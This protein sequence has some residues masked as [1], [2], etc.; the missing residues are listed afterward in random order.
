MIALIDNSDYFIYLVKG[1][2]LI[3]PYNPPGFLE[4]QVKDAHTRGLTGDTL[5]FRKGEPSSPDGISLTRNTNL[6]EVVVSQRVLERV[7]HDN[8]E[9]GTRYDG[10]NKLTIKYIN[11][12]LESEFMRIYS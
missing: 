2:A 7:V 3:P 4:C 10:S 6:L 11:P 1:D 8:L 5:R 9:V 12:L